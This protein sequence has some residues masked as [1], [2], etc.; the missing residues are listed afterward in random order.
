MLDSGISNSKPILAFYESA[1]AIIKN[2]NFGIIKGV[3]FFFK[4]IIKYYIRK[5]LWKKK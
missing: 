5:F 2:K 3:N 4:S 1:S